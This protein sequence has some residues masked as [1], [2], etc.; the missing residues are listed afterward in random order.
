MQR[1][2]PVP[3]D[4]RL[5]NTASL[6][7]LLGLVLLGVVVGVRWVTRMPAFD[8][9]KITVHG[10]TAHSNSA[11]L[12][13]NVS[14]R[15]HDSFF[16]VDLQRVRNAFEAL[17]WVRHAVVRR[18]FPNRLQV[19]LEEHQAVAFWGGEA[20]MR[21]VNH[22]GEVFDANTGEVEQDGLP[23]LVGP[24]TQSAEILAMYQAIA[25]LFEAVDASV[26]ELELTEQ[27]S[28]RVQ[29]GSDAVIE[30]GRGGIEAV[31]ARVHRFT[32]TLTQI[33]SRYGRQ[34]SAIESADLRHDNGYAIRLQGVSTTV[35]E[36]NKAMEK[37]SR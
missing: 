4:I 10:D 13:A 11:T 7:L 24:Q 26:A 21:L 9:Q 33:V 37:N 22:W 14:P 36:G 5:M 31:H 20:G 23:I 16:N 17:P 1:M 2:A 28:W 34:T 6:A 19:L 32:K 18:V 3:T 27:G 12:R 29:L 15:I 35:G 30:L 25:P 8:I